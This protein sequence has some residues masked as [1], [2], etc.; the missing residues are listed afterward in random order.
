M[1]GRPRH[2]YAWVVATKQVVDEMRVLTVM[3]AREANVVPRQRKT[4]VDGKA[5]FG[6]RVAEIMD[7]SFV[8]HIIT[9]N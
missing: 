8:P 1:T 6:K 7:W 2:S 5:G 4:Y 3:K 9:W